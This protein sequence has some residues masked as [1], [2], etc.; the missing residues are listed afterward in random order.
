MPGNKRIT[1]TEGYNTDTDTWT[2][3][4]NGKTLEGR[5]PRQLHGQVARAVGPDVEVE[6][7]VRLSPEHQQRANA[8]VKESAVLR[9][10]RKELLRRSD[11]LNIERVK[12]SEELTVQ[13][14][15]QDMIA[16]VVDLPTSRLQQICDPISQAGSRLRQIRTGQLEAGAPPRQGDDE[17]D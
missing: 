12:L 8:I 2:A 17:E 9:K 11:L 4:V 3:V 6:R 7:R 16:E 15:T 10:L 14:F 13:R 1:V 5:T